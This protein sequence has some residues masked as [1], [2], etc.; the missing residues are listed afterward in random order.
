M[1]TDLHLLFSVCPEDN[2]VDVWAGWSA[3]A[4]VVLLCAM[5]RESQG[6][7]LSHEEKHRSAHPSFFFLVHYSQYISSGN[8]SERSQVHH[9]RNA[10]MS[11][12]TEKDQVGAELGIHRKGK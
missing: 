9:K 6:R 10:L 2:W 8:S 5:C 11:S 4:S 3:K 7:L 1:L 12:Y